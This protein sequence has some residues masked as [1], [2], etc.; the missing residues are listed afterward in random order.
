MSTA[1]QDAPLL[2]N[3]KEAAH[4]LNCC[5]K[6]VYTIRKQGKIPFMRLGNAIRYSRAD[7]IK[8]IETQSKTSTDNAPEV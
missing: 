3:E 1:L 8:F 2:L 4:L 5:E 7:L 6:T